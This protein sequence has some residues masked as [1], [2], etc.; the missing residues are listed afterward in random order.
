MP[1]ALQHDAD[2]G[3]MMKRVDEL[4][5]E[6][7]KNAFP[8]AFRPPPQDRPVSDY[9]PGTWYIEMTPQQRNTRISSKMIFA[10]WA[11]RVEYDLVKDIG[12]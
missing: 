2:E 10:S 8:D 12:R 11:L 3:K 9:L 1:A 4:T 5:E 7:V 6:L